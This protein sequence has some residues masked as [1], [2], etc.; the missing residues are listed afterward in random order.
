[1]DIISCASSGIPLP[2]TIRLSGA[3]SVERNTVRFSASSSLRKRFVSGIWVVSIGSPIPAI[4]FHTVR[5]VRSFPVYRPDSRRGKALSVRLVRFLTSSAATRPK[6]ACFPVPFGRTHRS[7]DVIHLRNGAQ[8]AR[9][10]HRTGQ[11]E[12]QQV[13]VSTARQFR[14]H[15]RR[16]FHQHFCTG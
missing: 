2:A 7:E 10:V 14:R 15:V 11:V 5:T 1:M 6:R 16:T 8:Y 9:R 4:T 13:I 3:N 12:E